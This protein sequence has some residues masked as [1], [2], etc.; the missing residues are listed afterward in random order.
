MKHTTEWDVRLYLSEEDGTT[1]A[2]AVL[3]T[4]TTTLDAHG[5]ARR[6]PADSDVPEIGD[7][8]SASRALEDLSRRL[9]ATAYGDMEAVGATEP[10]PIRRDPR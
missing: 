9:L 3:N 5:T 1:T 4:G 10:G 7:E 8:L 2:H 6:N